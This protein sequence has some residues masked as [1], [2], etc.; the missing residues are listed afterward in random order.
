MMFQEVC[1]VCACVC[2]Y[3]LQ[4]WSSEQWHAGLTCKR[5]YVSKEQPCLEEGAGKHGCTNHACMHSFRHS[6]MVTKNLAN[7]W[8]VYL[9]A[10]PHPL[11]E[12]VHVK[13]SCPGTP[14]HSFCSAL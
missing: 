14:R 10:K 4:Q 5:S 12:H 13:G 7:V 2:V 8:P 11:H 6:L 1:S 3:K 9:R